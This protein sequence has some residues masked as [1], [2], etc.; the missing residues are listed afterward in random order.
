MN[1]EEDFYKKLTNSTNNMLFEI[2]LLKNKLFIKEI[3]VTEELKIAE[4][5][6]F[7]LKSSSTWFLFCESSKINTVEYLKKDLIY[8]ASNINKKLKELREKKEEIYEIMNFMPS[9]KRTLLTEKTL[10]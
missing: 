5:N 4:D 8:F 7:Y 9:H 6:N 3:I 10:L 2:L 1:K